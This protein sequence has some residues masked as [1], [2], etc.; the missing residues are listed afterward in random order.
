MG[1]R[2]ACYLGVP[3][4]LGCAWPQ[5]GHRERAP[6]MWSPWGGPVLCTQRLSGEHWVKRGCQLFPRQHSTAQP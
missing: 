4:P 3:L 1:A 6:T 5:G 2:R